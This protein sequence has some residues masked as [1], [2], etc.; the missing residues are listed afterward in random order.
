VDE[1][2][3]FT[4]CTNDNKHAAPI[5]SH[6]ILL[7]MCNNVVN[8]NIVLI[9]TLLSLISMAFKL[10]YKQERMM[11]PNAVFQQCFDWFV[12]KYG[13]DSAEDRK[14]N[15]MAMAANWHT[16]M[17][18]EVLTSHL[19][20][21]VTFASLS[22]HPIVDKDTVDI[23]IHVLNPMGLFPKEYKTWILRGADTSK[24]N[25]FV[26]FKTFWENA[27]QIAAFTAF[28]ASQHE[29]S[30]AP[31]NNNASAHLLTD[32]VSN[33]GTAYSATQ[34]PL[35]FNTTNI[36]VIRGQLQMLCQAVGTSQPL[37]NS[38]DTPK[39][40]VAVASNTAETTAVA[41]VVA[42][43]AVAVVA[44]TMAAAVVAT[45]TAV[46]A[47]ARVAA[48]EMQM[49][50]AVTTA[51]AMATAVAAGEIRPQASPHQKAVQELKLLFHPWR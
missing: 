34:E 39:M 18:F 38:H 43:A 35:Q 50:V 46:A 48:A 21:V 11:D 14:T 33:F 27:V 16:S 47:T 19:F 49:V 2:P 42:T 31:T 6:A 23:G 44:T 3:N 24:T 40:D 25:D 29:Y 8:M 51:A 9:N 7:K 15:R 32:A 28:P 5:I 10:L 45:T 1:V 26:S 4:A 13:R 22:R 36:A 37:R 20:H 30:M 41:T 12:I 17:G